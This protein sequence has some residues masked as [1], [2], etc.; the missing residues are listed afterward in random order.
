MRAVQLV[1]PLLTRTAARVAALVL[2]VAL[3]VAAFAAL[4]EAPGGAQSADPPIAGNEYVESWA[5]SPTGQDPTQP[6]TRPNLVYT[7][8]PG[9]T[10]EDSVTLWNYSSR[11]VTFRLLATDA[12]NNETGDFSLLKSSEAPEDLGAWISLGTTVVTIP[13]RTSGVIPIVLKVPADA[14]PGDHAA[15]ILAATDTVGVDGQGTEVRLD[16]RTGPR[17]Y[18]RVSGPVNPELVVEDLSSKYHGRF[19]PFSGSLEVEYTV[20]NPGNV[21]LGARQTLVVTDIF[22]RT[23]A[24]QPLRRIDELLPGNAVTFRETVDGVPATLRVKATIRLEPFA[25][26]DV[27]DRDAPPATSATTAAWAIPW[28]LLLVLALAYLLWRIARRWRG[29][30]DPEEPPAAAPPSARVPEP[31]GR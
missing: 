8:A 16:R 29:E 10:L 23:V 19:N 4:T 21:R 15:A 31:V 24:E 26:R 30:E 12:F 13:P 20:R 9:G 7:V 22:G 18:L 28:T 27:S 1:N 5:L 11:P 17:V 3:C 2:V 25:P 6:G 14:D